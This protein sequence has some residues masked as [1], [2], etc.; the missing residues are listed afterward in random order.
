MT[1]KK[2]AVTNP[3]AAGRRAFTEAWVAE[4]RNLAAL[5]TTVADEFV[6]VLDQVEAAEASGDQ[7][8]IRL[9]SNH[10]HALVDDARDVFS[11]QSDFHAQAMSRIHAVAMEHAPKELREA[12]ERAQANAFARLLTEIARGSDGPPLS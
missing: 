1:V 9:A 6:T 12:S 2:T 4:L 3:L 7:E 5:A 10:G 11:G 8:A